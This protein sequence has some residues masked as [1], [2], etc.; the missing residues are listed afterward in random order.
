MNIIKLIVIALVLY[1]AY[2]IYRFLA[3]PSAKAQPKVLQSRK[4]V[5]GIDLVEDPICHTYIPLPNVY[6]K[7]VRNNGETLYFCSEKCFEQFKRQTKQ[8]DI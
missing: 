6:K 3:L 8:E 5:K 7:V 2:R 1:V 4:E